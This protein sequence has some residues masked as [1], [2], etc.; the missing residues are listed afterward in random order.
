MIII[1]NKKEQNLLFNSSFLLF[2]KIGFCNC[3][4]TLGIGSININF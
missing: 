2:E 1:N 3:I 4:F